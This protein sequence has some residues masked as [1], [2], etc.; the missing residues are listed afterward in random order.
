MPCCRIK[1]CQVPPLKRS[2]RTRPRPYSRRIAATSFAAATGLNG[3]RHSATRQMTVR[4]PPR[5]EE[6]RVGKE[7]RSRWAAD[8]LKKK[9]KEPT[10]T[11]AAAQTCQ[12][13]AD[14]PFDTPDRIQ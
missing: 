11:G 3:G 12:H 14:T 6:R 7:G 9:I 4:L 1:S 5:S 13:K 10:E 2:P 8:H